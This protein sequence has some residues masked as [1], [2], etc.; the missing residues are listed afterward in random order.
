M[1]SELHLPKQKTLLLRCVLDHLASPKS[2]YRVIAG[3]TNI[4]KH[5]SGRIL[6]EKEFNT[7]FATTTNVYYV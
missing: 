7:F 6:A 2:I 5:F 4:Q 1:L 3:T